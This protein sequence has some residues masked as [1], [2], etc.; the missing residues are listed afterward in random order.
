MTNKEKPNKTSVTQ[1][2]ENQ[3]RSIRDRIDTEKPYPAFASLPS[4]R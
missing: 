3:K 2:L 1:R 4:G